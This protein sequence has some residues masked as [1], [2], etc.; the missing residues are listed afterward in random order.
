MTEWKKYEGTDEQI[1]EMMDKNIRF[2]THNDRYL[3]NYENFYDEDDL[4]DW[5]LRNNITEYLII[6]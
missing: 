4:R 5:F 3:F 6:P 1:A 2:A